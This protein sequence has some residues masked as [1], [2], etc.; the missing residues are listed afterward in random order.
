MLVV[1]LPEDHFE[2]ALPEIE[3]HHA[4]E[5]GFGQQ[6]YPIV[7]RKESPLLLYLRVALQKLHLVGLQGVLVQ[8]ALLRNSL[9][10]CLGKHRHIFRLLDDVEET[11]PGLSGRF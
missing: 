3:Q 11:F 10:H 2:G 4:D 7:V 1:A 6:N 8:G 9:F 5:H